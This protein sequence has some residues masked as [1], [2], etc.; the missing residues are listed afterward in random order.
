M[1][2]TRSRSPRV[3]L[4]EEGSPLH[5]AVIG[6]D[7]G[8]GV[9]L[10]RPEVLLDDDVD[11]REWAFVPPLLE[12]RDSEVEREVYSLAPLGRY[13]VGYCTDSRHISSRQQARACKHAPELG[14]RSDPG[15]TL[16][17][18]TRTTAATTLHNGRDDATLVADGAP[19]RRRGGVRPMTGQRARRWFLDTLAR[20]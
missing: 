14:G 19:P 18:Y 10:L 6:K 17:A 9:G 11:G 8:L 20:C 7:G 15:F 3:L 4:L 2:S 16:R 13:G 5:G 1:P 12:L